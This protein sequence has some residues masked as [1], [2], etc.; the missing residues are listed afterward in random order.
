M[1][2]T[3]LLYLGGEKDNDGDA[4]GDIGSGGGW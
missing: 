4:G 1:K 3:I 2:S